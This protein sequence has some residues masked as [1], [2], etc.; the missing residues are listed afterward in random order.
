MK[1]ETSLKFTRPL[2][3]T[4]A[5]LASAPA[6]SQGVTI[7]GSMDL[8]LEAVSGRLPGG[9][10]R[11]TSGR[12]SN[13]MS[14]PH[15]GFRGT[16]DLGGGLGAAFNLEASVSADNGNF[17]LN[18][19]FGRQS[20]V[21]LFGEFG[22]LRLGRQYTMFRY[23]FEDANPWGYGNHGL[24]LLDE[25]ISNPRA[26][27]AIS[28]IGK[29]GPVRAG[30]NYS[31]GRD[32]ADGNSS[33]ATNCPGETADPK[34]CREYSAY[35]EYEGG[36]WGVATAYERLHGGT[37]KTFAGLTSPDKTDTRFVLGGRV[38][39]NGGTQLAAGWIKRNNEGLAATPKSDMVWLQAIV[40]FAGAFSVDGL[41]G[42]LKY[43]DSPNKAVLVNLRG[44][45]ALSK[46]TTLYL[47]GSY[48]DNSGTLALSATGS[49]PAIRPAPGAS[50]T[51]V[52]AGVVHYF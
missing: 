26:D 5:L 33:A 39:L 4:A 30:M 3:V 6:W 29:W 32:A 50:Q 13:G 40:P 2:L 28:Y 22:T 20:W 48:I 42:Q 16:E 43:E 38:N 1:P 8:G 35:A 14:T 49:T 45:Y 52:I 27:N 46:R 37:D 25:R 24:R 7:Y 23:G 12:L 15:F 41:L 19:G 11:D 18:R 9:S 44:R 34:Q 31:F 36:S 10:E 17:G 51:S 21:G 47:S